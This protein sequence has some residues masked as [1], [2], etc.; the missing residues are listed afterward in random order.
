MT[1]KTTVFFLTLTASTAA[2]AQTAMPPSCQFRCSAEC[3]RD[4]NQVQREISTYL[5]SCG[6]TP[7]PPPPIGGGLVEIYH[8]DSCN[9]DLIAAVSSNTNCSRLSGP[10]AWGVK[11]NGRCLDIPDMPLEQA[12]NLYKNG[13]TGIN[14]YHSDS[15]SGE[16]MGSI[17][18]STDCSK[19]LTSSVW[20]IEVNGKCYDISDRSAV[21][22][23][24]AYRSTS[25]GIK[26]FHSDSCSSEILAIS[27]GSTSCEEQAK[28]V[29][30]SVW[31]IE[32]NGTC[33]DISDTDFLSACRRFVGASI[34]KKIKPQQ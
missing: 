4:L 26:F 16:F 8:S 6:G 19:Q 13:A 2:L 3:V 25:A 17:G 32:I 33:Q 18:P 9:G 7:V 15:C 22:I 20:G 11:I 12:C 31:G 1:L 21:A 14:F 30:Q 23:C 24:P 27:D 10:S 34:L 5:Q 28:A 29:S